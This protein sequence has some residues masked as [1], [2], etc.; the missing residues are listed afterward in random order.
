MSDLKMNLE[1]A[2][3]AFQQQADMSVDRLRGTADSLVEDL[4]KVHDVLTGDSAKLT[5]V[6]ADAACMMDFYISYDNVSDVQLN[7]SGGS[8][9]Y[10]KLVTPLKRGKYRAVILLNRLP[11]ETPL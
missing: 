7:L 1:D 4:K 10:S 11:D 6:G 3:H 2:I 9:S 5:V 8:G